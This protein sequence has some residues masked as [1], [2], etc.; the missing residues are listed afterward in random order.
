[1]KINGRNFTFRRTQFPLVLAY[2]ITSHSVQGITKEKVIIDYG[3]NPAK[4]ALFFVP[5]SRAKTLDGIFLKDFKR[6]YVHCDQ[7]FLKNINVWRLQQGTNLKTHIYMFLGFTIQV[8]RRY[9]CQKL[10]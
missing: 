9:Q 4:H 6:E 2:A 5:F 1:M 10:K 3:S 7:Q 8:L